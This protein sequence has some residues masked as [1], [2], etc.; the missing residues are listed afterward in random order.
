MEGV[1]PQPRCYLNRHTCLALIAS[2]AVVS[3]G[4]AAF[5]VVGSNN[6]VTTYLVV[7]GNA[8]DVAKLKDFYTSGGGGGQVMDG[9][10]HSGPLICEHDS[11]GN[12]HHLHFALYGSVVS[13][14]Q[15]QQI[16]SA[17]P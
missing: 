5:T 7:S 16:F 4:T 3:C 6:G 8:D 15:C 9:D 11:T 10:E 13:T 14:Q 17:F 2:F 12:G 1:S